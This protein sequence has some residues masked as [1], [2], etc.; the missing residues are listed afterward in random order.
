MES[1]TLEPFED[2][3]QRIVELGNRLA[4]TDPDADVWELADG[5]LA[6]AVH[7]WLYARQP[8]ENPSCQDCADVSTAALRLS[9]LLES[10]KEFAES[11][12]YYHCPNDRDVGRA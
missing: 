3:A 8:C 10:T 9:Q 4:D 5:L 6:G 11:S 1:K 12:E 2:A 7:F